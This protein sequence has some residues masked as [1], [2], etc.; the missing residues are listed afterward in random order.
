MIKYNRFNVRQ[1]PGTVVVAVVIVVIVVI[2]IIIIVVVVVVVGGILKI[3]RPTPCTRHRAPIDRP[4]D[5]K[6][7]TENILVPIS[8]S[9]GRAS[10]GTFAYSQPLSLSRQPLLLL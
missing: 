6:V 5:R 9:I 4:I 2:I 8:S 3:G 7:V 1:R 10:L